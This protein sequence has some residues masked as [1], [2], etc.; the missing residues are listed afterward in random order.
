MK[1]HSPRV[2][3]TFE[4]D[5]VIQLLE[6]LHPLRRVAIREFSATRSCNSQ[7]HGDIVKKKHKLNLVTNQNRRRRTHQ[8]DFLRGRQCALSRPKDALP[9]QKK[10][11]SQSLWQGECDKITVLQK[12]VRHHITLSWETELHRPVRPAQAATRLILLTDKM[13]GC[14]NGM[15]T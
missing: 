2:P 11:F 9:R 12:N 7:P 8:W 3:Y 1:K 5:F 14:C 10:N 4:H 6:A 15:P 13:A